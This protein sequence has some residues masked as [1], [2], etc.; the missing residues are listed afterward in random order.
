MYLHYKIC[1]QVFMQH[2]TTKRNTIE[3]CYSS[4]HY[5]LYNISE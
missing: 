2:C 1:P 5:D 4:R 3:S